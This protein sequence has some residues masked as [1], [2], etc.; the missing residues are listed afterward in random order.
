MQVS[1]KQVV[2]LREKAC[3]ER[4]ASHH[5]AKPRHGQDATIELTGEERQTTIEAT[6]L[7]TTTATTIR[8]ITRTAATNNNKTT[9]NPFRLNDWYKHHNA[10]R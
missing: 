4:Q 8:R 10:A 7:A 5:D 1:G 3:L 2:Q 9:N 6:T